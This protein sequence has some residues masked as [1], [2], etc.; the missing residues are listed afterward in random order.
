M[1]SIKYFP[2][3]IFSNKQ[4]CVLTFWRNFILLNFN[5]FYFILFYIIGRHFVRQLKTCSHRKGD[6][7]S[8]DGSFVVFALYFELRKTKRCNSRL[9]IRFFQCNGGQRK[10]TCQIDQLQYSQQ[11]GQLNQL[12]ILGKMKHSPGPHWQ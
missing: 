11:L 7:N 12:K 3:R 1:N 4:N 6:S 2:N 9:T 5:L 10:H 8:V